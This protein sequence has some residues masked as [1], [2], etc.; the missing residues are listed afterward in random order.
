MLHLFLKSPPLPLSVEFPHIPKIGYVHLLTMVPPFGHHTK[1]SCGLSNPI[2]S[3]FHHFDPPDN[4]NRP[5]CPFPFSFLDMLSTTFHFL[6]VI[7]T[8]RWPAPPPSAPC[9][10]FF[11]HSTQPPGGVP[12]TGAFFNLLQYCCVSPPGPPPIFSHGGLNPFLSP[13]QWTSN[14]CLFLESFTLVLNFSPPAETPSS[15]LL[16]AGL[17]SHSS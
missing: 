12:N 15:G 16:C 13:L 2:L 8:P 6:L 10:F 7:D 17:P 14:S 11:H 4:I 3:F 5:S 9:P 1:P